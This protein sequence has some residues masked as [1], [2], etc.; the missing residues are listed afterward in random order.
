MTK[1]G[2]KF[3]KKYYSINI[4]KLVIKKIY[5]LLKVLQ[6]MRIN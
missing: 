6:C 3:Y 1:V 5:I 4:G 2:N